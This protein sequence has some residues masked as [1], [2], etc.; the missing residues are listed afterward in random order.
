MIVFVTQ[1]LLS[2]QKAPNGIY[3]IIFLFELGIIIKTL[4]HFRDITS[5]SSVFDVKKQ[6]A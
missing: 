2:K 3:P 5:F 1:L 6:N 4:F